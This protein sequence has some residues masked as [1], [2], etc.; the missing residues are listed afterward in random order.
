VGLT[1]DVTDDVVDQAVTELLVGV[2]G[3]LAKIEYKRKMR[4]IQSGIRAA[5]DAGK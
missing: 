1:I 5:Q 2:M 4:R 3:Q